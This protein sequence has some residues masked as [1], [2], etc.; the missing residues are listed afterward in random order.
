MARK[1]SKR[2]EEMRQFI[3]HAKHIKVKPGQILVPDM[4]IG[5]DD[6][7][8]QYTLDDSGVEVNVETNALLTV[9]GRHTELASPGVYKVSTKRKTIRVAT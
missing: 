3:Y 7:F 8:T 6:A 5:K 1:T 9:A 2:L 4:R